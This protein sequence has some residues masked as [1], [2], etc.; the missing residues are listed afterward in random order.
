M[1][2]SDPPRDQASSLGCTPSPKPSQPRLLAG[3]ASFQE[4]YKISYISFIVSWLELLKVQTVS[5]FLVLVMHTDWEP[6]L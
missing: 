6:N 1:K 2:T 4:S 3:V 5:I